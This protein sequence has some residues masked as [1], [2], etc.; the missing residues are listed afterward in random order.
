M[1]ITKEIIEAIEKAKTKIKF[2]EA[3]GI[4][5]EK[6]PESAWLITINDIINRTALAVRDELEILK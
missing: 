3:F 1:E 4:P 5:V 2:I 6:Q